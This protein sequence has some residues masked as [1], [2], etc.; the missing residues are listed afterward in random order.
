MHAKKNRKS[1]FHKLKVVEHGGCAV[2]RRNECCRTLYRPAVRDSATL[3]AGG[4]K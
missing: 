3:Y 4:G 2:Q 1:A